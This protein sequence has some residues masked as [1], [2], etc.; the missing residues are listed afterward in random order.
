MTRGDSILPREKRFWAGLALLLILAG[1][2][3][4]RGYQV[5]LPY[6]VHVDE[7]Q[8]LLAA[9][10]LIDDGT[11]RAVFH[12]AS[13]P[14]ASRL[15]YLFLKHVKAPDDPPGL[16]LPTLRLI[17]IGAWLLVVVLIALLGR[18]IAN[19]LCGLM[20][21]AIWIVNPWVVERAHFVLPDGYLTLFALLALWLALVGAL[22]SHSGF[23]AAAMYSLM[24]AIVFKTQAIFVAPLVILSPL[25]LSLRDGD[26]L[27]QVFWNCVR[28]GVFL[29]WL[30]LLYPT[31]E[32]SDI[33]YW[34][35]RTDQAGPHALGSIGF[36][37]SQTLS[38]FASL[39]G[40][41]A[42]AGLALMCV[43]MR[44][45]DRMALAG[46]AVAAFSYLFGVSLFGAQHLRQFFV[47]G[48]LLVI[49]MA[50]GISGGIYAG[51]WV[52]RRLGFHQWRGITA[53]SLAAMIACIALA[54][55]LLP[56]YR[57]SDALA[58][59][60]SLPDRRV[61]LMRYFDTSLEPGKYLADYDNH[62]TFNRA[63]GGYDG[64]N[65][66]PRYPQNARLNDRPID[67]W[68]AMGVDYAIAPFHLAPNDPQETVLL[69][70][71]PPD[72][73]FR[74]PAV[75]AL[76][77]YPMQNTATG[78]LGG[79]HLKGYD[80][81]ASTAQA[82]DDIILRHYWQAESAPETALHIFNH[83]LDA[84]GQI[85]AQV[86]GIPLYDSR[87]DTTSWDDADEI[88]LGRN[89]ILRLP[90]DLPSGE[91]TLI[92][93]FYDPFTGIRLMSVDG[94]DH[95]PIAN[96]KISAASPAQ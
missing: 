78:Q 91:Y 61:E 47:L 85:A 94:D 43:Y 11:A 33:P 46:L 9:Q 37:L 35:A 96:I 88:M 5:G 81:S 27:R 19:P 20:A 62:K 55:S 38:Q 32:Q 26:A 22:H 14:G 21:A 18:M 92:S 16:M 63:W 7:P 95:L 13:P 52:L 29:F 3:Y 41:I 68:R 28:F 79:I 89:F 58:H 12:E 1:W 60:F 4:L 36:N 24:L 69:K 83:L 54:A 25:A 70:S 65:D 50:L 67:E 39:P 74:G 2:L 56:H 49:F 71:F 34:P 31:L 8:H 57:E 51:G 23:S 84:D 30:L 82:G 72:A 59:D 40:W 53:D 77:L 86:D 6:L 15:I 76:R 42:L 73:N 93:G 17:T 90:A 80:L 64:V 87:R 44:L 75:V 66:F 48:A 45:V 10:H